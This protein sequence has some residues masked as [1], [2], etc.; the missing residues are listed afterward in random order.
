MNLSLQTMHAR[1]DQLSDEFREVREGVRKA[2]L[3]AEFDPE[4]ALTRARKVLE[5]VVREV[6]QR[7]V[8]ES[9]GTRPLENL[10]QRLVKDRVLPDRLD[11]YATTV[12]KLGNVGTHSFG[13]SVTVADVSR[14]LLHLE[15]ILEWYFEVERPDGLVRNPAG[16]RQRESTDSLS[17]EQ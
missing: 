14:S 1:L 15:P 2:I 9:P 3:V 10:V 5:L 6:Y 11:A 4:M 16:V 12:R 7:R 13:E 8:R 17:R